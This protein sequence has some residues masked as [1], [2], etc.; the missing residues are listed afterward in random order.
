MP[1]H[2]FP[3]AVE[4]LDSKVKT[5][6]S[7]F[8]QVDPHDACEAGK[9]LAGMFRSLI[10]S[11]IDNDT[12]Q[13]TFQQEMA[14]DGF[15]YDLES[16]P[17]DEADPSNWSTDDCRYFLGAR[18]GIDPGLSVDFYDLSG[19][20]NFIAARIEDYEDVGCEHKRGEVETAQLT[21]NPHRK[22]QVCNEITLD[23]NDE[24]DEECEHGNAVLSDDNE[25]ATYHCP[26]CGENFIK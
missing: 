7:E 25:P 9:K 11:G 14:D 19:W 12:V 2:I 26:D 24:E 17:V 15:F 6:E 1:R 8:F 3:S 23:L 18:L 22:C 16:D 10:A 20:R 21:G 4:W 5:L 13:D